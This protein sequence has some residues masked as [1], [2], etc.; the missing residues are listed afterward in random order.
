MLSTWQDL[1]SLGSKLPGTTI[2]DDLASDMPFRDYIDHINWV[3]NTHTILWV[4]VMECMKRRKWT[5]HS[6]HCSLILDSGCNVTSC[7]TVL[8]LQ[9]PYHGGCM[10]MN[11]NKHL[12]R[13]LF[14]SKY[15]FHSRQKE[16]KTGH[17][18]QD[19]YLRGCFSHLQIYF[20][21]EINIKFI[22]FIHSSLSSVMLGVFRSFSHHHHPYPEHLQHPKLSPYTH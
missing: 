11:E 12:L 18:N 13:S 9:L 14:M 2:R 5:E 10:K 8:L 19:I 6:I 7:L 17:L 4:W 20:C 1:E 16:T 15:F 22:M 21:H 3:E